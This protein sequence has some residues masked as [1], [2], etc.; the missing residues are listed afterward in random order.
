MVQ[1]PVAGCPLWR[2]LR[3]RGH[4]R[5]KSC[6]S[7]LTHLAPRR[8]PRDPLCR[9]E[10]WR[11]HGAFLVKAWQSYA[12]LPALAT[13]NPALVEGLMGV[14]MAAAALNRVVAH[15]PHRLAEGPLSTRQVAMGAMDG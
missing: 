3:L 1:W 4:R 13:A 15:M 14:A 12:K 2:R 5:T 6:C 9:A 8:A 10:Q 7:V 11:G